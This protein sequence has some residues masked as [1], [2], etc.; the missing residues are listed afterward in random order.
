MRIFSVKT[1][2]AIACTIVIGLTTVSGFGQAALHKALDFDGDGKTDLSV[3][4][5]SDNTWYV[6]KTDGQY[7]FQQFGSA[8]ED[9]MTPGDWDGDGKGDVAVWRDTNGAFYRLNS[10]DNTFSGMFF[11]MSG[12]EPVARDYDGDGRTDAAVV[13]R[14]NGSMIWYVWGSQRGFFANY[15]GASTDYAVPGD[16]DGDG[17]F[18][19]T[20]QR[21]G[22]TATDIATFYILSSQ[23]GGMLVHFWGFG[24]DLA[25]PGDYDGDGKTDI[26]V[27][28]EGPTPESA[29]EWYIEQS[30]DGGFRGY[31]WGATG[32]DILVQGDYDGDGRTDIGVWRST[33]GYYYALKSSDGTMRFGGWGLPTDYP[34]ASYDTH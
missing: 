22:A 30:S 13:R 8:N 3:F 32:T 6:A 21:P 9:F 29:L 31:A 10:S 7:L 5:P 34:I 27:V 17:K 1:V 18:D 14:A 11:G 12:D 33:E 15:W 28:R 19:F 20:V 16:Y 4:R 23:T 24:T 25:V 26:A 2:R